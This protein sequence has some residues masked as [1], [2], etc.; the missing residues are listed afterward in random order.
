MNPVPP[1]EAQEFGAA[2]PASSA[3]CSSAWDS[4]SATDWSHWVTAM[5]AD[6]ASTSGSSPVAWAWTVR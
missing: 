1:D 6:D 3:S 5:R 2:G 4:T